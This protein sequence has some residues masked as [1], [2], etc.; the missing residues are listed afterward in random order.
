MATLSLQIWVESAKALLNGTKEVNLDVIAIVIVS[1]AIGF[2][3]C[4]YAYCRNYSRLP[5][6]KILA[7]DHLNDVIFNSFGLVFSTLGARFASWIDP[8]GAILI[9]FFIMK[10]WGST[11]FENIRLIVGV[12]AETAFLN[13]VVYLSMTHDP[14][15][16][17]VDTCRAY[18]SGYNVFVEVDVILP[19]DMRLNEAHDIGEDLQIKIESLPEVDRAFVH[20]D[21][22]HFHLPEHRR[23][24]SD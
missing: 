8:A 3:L 14:R 9:A 2:K 18:H 20:L 6:I 7:Q 15:I 1:C 17:Q 24:K 19:P 13:R 11:A 10:S 21:H 12:S 23:P 4:L 5:S 22:T 16:L